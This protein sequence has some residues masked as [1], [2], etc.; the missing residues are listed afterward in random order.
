MLTK[1]QLTT[2]ISEAVHLLEC[3]KKLKKMGA[4]D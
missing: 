3:F 4:D 1:N 2:E